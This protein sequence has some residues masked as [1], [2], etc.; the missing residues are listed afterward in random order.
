M[1]IIEEVADEGSSF[2]PTV[3]FFNEDGG[4]FTPTTLTWK[5][6]D[7]RGNVVNSRSAVVVGAPSTTLALELTG[8]DL[9]V[10]GDNVVSRLI[11]VW[12]TYVSATYGSGQPFSYQ[13]M[14]NIQPRVGG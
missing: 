3:S 7:M 2:Y 12:G 4:A 8:A 1:Q 9:E 6:T 11:T 10:I 13:A 5:L 14:F